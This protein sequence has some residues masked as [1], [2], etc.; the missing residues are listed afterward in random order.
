MLSFRY[1]EKQI[2]GKLS[3]VDLIL[4]SQTPEDHIWLVY[5]FFCHEAE[6]Y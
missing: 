3:H 4:I 6:G 1:G 5:F 2:R